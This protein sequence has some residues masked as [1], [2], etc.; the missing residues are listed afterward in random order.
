MGFLSRFQYKSVL[1]QMPEV[2]EHPVFIIAM[3]RCGSTALFSAL[4]KN[5][6]ILSKFHESP[7]IWHVAN[8]VYRYEQ[9]ENKK[10]YNGALGISK[11]WLYLNFK[12]LIFDNSVGEFF[13]WHYYKSKLGL[14]SDAGK[15]K[16]WLAKTFPTKEEY[17]GM[18]TLF[19]HAKYIY[20]HRDGIGQI[21]S[22]TKFPDHSGRDFKYYCENWTH[23]AKTFRYLLTLNNA[24]SISHSEMLNNPEAVIRKIYGLLSTEFFQGSVDFL[25][26]NVVHPLNEGTKKNISAQE[27]FK[28]RKPV[29]EEWTEEQ[30]KMFKEICG[31]EMKILGY[32]ISF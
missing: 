17:E 15:K 9:G 14:N 13:W 29:Y 21:H 10:Y 23:H 18:K 19:P 31:E 28:E 11:K 12:K 25:K 30:R 5:P 32:E 3:G 4:A 27:H 22:S 6:A 20:L 16:F 2:T 24:V 7:F 8:L 26:N 1:L